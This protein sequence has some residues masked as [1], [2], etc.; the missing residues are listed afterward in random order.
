MT[1]T[2]SSDAAR[3]DVSGDVGGDGGGAPSWWRGFSFK[4]VSLLY[5]WVAIIVLFAFWLPDTF[6]TE[7]T[8]RSILT[9][10][11]IVAIMA[12]GVV[13]SLSAHAFDLA[14]GVNMGFAS[15]MCAWALVHWGW[16]IPA[17]IAIG[18]LAAT[19]VGGVNAFLVS[20]L[21]IDTFIATIGVTSVLTGVV[22]A[23][24]DN[25]DIVGLPLSFQDLALNRFLGIEYPVYVMIVLAIVLWYV[26]EHTPFG[27]YVYAT[28]SAPEAARLAGLRTHRLVALTLIITGVC[29]GIAGVLLTAQVGGSSPSLGAP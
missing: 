4:N 28:G 13:V 18:I 15:I 6:L 17:A 20:F 27:R 5:V 11:T 8:W 23:V 12:M 26:L 10:Q 24:P 7:T 14:V 29:T 3:G 21:K 25:Q 19:F 9:S 2:V 16:S 1:E 22:V